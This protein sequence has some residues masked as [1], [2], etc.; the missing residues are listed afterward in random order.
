[1]VQSVKGKKT[2]TIKM[3]KNKNTKH[4]RIEKEVLLFCVFLF[5]CFLSFFIHSFFAIF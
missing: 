1:M 2:H 4:N 3:E 5:C